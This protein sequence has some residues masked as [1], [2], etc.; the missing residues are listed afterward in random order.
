MNGRK[1]NIIP[2][3]KKGNQQIIKN[4]RPVSLSPICGKIFEEIIFYSLFK[5][6]KDNKLLTCSHSS[7]WPGHS[8]VHWLLSDLQII[9]S[10]LK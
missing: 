9:I 4:Y 8:C 10:Y 5:C 2:V 6:L 1:T 7:F 3:D